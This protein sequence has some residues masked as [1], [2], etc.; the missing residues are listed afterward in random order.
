MLGPQLG[1]W[2]RSTDLELACP[3]HGHVMHLID[4][5]IATEI[6]NSTSYR[7][8]VTHQLNDQKCGGVME[9]TRREFLQAAALAVP[10]L[11]RLS[12]GQLHAEPTTAV[13]ESQF[14][15]GADVYPDIQTSEATTRMLDDLQRA[16]MNVVRVGESNWG[17][18]ETAPGKFNF[19]WLRA[20]LD[21]LES[22]QM[23][24]IL[25]TS[26]FIP[27]QWL[28]GAHPE[29]LVVLQPGMGPSD[30]MSRKCPCLNQPLYREACERYITA[31]GKEFVTH[32]AV[33]AWQLD[34]EIEFLVS[35]IC[36]N[37]ACEEAWRQ[38]LE[39][40]YHTPE[41]FNDRLDLTSWGMK[42]D[43]FDEVP[44]PRPGV[45]HPHTEGFRKA[46]PAL[47]LANYQFRHD[48]ILGFL[49]EQAKLLR[50][51]GVKQSILTDWN[52]VWLALADSTQAQD[53]MSIAGLNYYQSSTDQRSFWNGDPWQFDMHRSCYG[54]NRF[55]VTETRFGVTGDTAMWD[56][57]PTREQFRMWN[58]E[59]VAF[60]ASGLLYWTGNRWRGGHWPHWGGLLDWMGHTEPDFA[61]AVE[62]GQFFR[63]WG[64]VLLAHSVKS[65][66]AVLTDF[67]NRAALE[68]YPH[69]PTSRSVFM[70][71]F[72]SLHRLG[73]G[74]DTVNTRL[75]AD[76]NNLQKYALVLLPATTAFDDSRA[77]AALQ[78][79]VEAGG[80]LV[81]TPFTSY[82]DTSGVFRG[83]GFGANLTA[84]TG[85]VVR[86]ARWMGSPT[87]GNKQQQV[88][89]WNKLLTQQSPVGL[90]G[91]CE[92]LENTQ[93]ADIIASFKSDQSILDGRPAVTHRRVGKGTVIKLGFWPQDDSFLDLLESI[94]PLPN[95]ILV[96]GVP[97]GVLAVP[98]TDGSLFVVN[99]TDKQHDILLKRACVD[100]IS[101]GSISENYLLSSYQVLWLM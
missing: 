12:G 6:S 60:G 66:A 65:S 1:E 38:W 47:S 96:N 14:L 84:L 100:R 49:A 9:H 56:P 58:L 77:V 82:M 20:F 95:S 7:F 36:Y 79:Y 69:I 26:T 19:G 101:G 59:L 32:P 3:L 25:G 42:I 73:I 5:G 80:T 86:T 76:I 98:R 39:R 45:E 91:Y 33:L 15:F 16:Q 70:D 34:N 99:A 74:V 51:A 46:L 62:I 78:R 4:Q 64:S 8:I 67:S 11:S 29:T 40:T 44:Q 22:R 97:E 94:L 83:D 10:M 18:L 35:I 13:S 85:V 71:T 89:Q 57:A 31:L 27:P 63:K 28:V 81:I 87:N 72:S 93:N 30:P 23:K 50:E 61:W 92:Y 2:P 43:S 68:V 54:V 52:S 48:V 24:A 90:D 17:N 75:A 21:Q 41:E 53:F 88:V 37:P 55:I